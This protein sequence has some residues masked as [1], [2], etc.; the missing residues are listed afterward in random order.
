MS[1]KILR[2]AG[3]QARDYKGQAR[4]ILK[5]IHATI[6]YVN[7]AG[8]RLQSPIYTLDRR[9]ADCDD[10]AILYCSLA[11]AIALPTRLVLSGVDLATKEKV[12]WVEGQPQAPR[13]H[14]FSHIY[15]SVRTNPYNPKA[16]WLFVEPTLKT[17]DIGWDVVGADSDKLPE[18][19]LAGLMGLGSASAGSGGQVTTMLADTSGGKTINWQQVGLAVAAGVTVTVVSQIVLDLLRKNGIIRGEK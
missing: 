15:A 11:G 16:E 17:V 5:W 1:W 7:E 4:A 9:V 19:N 8:E 10:M 13:S 3:I 6:E 12:R 14:R 18:M 2:E